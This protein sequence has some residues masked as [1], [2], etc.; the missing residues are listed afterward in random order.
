MLETTTQLEKS[1]FRREQSAEKWHDA[2]M[3][4]PNPVGDKGHE[5]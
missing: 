3:T 4:L 1:I 5:P 2:L